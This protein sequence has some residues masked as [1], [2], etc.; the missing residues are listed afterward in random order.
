MNN[1]ITKTHKVC[2]AC[3]D[4]KSIDDFDKHLGHTDGRMG[5]CKSCVREREKERIERKRNAKNFW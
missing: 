4:E 2:R 3:E 5:T 1:D